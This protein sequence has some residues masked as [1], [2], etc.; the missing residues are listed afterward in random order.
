MEK[1]LILIYLLLLIN[2]ILPNDD[3]ISFKLETFQYK[4]EYTN[5]TIINKLYDTNLVTTMNIGSNYYPLKAFIDSQNNYFFISTKCNIQKSFFVDYKVNFNYDRHKSFSF[6]NTSSF[7]LSFSQESHA[8]TAREEFEIFKANKMETVK[9]TINF[10]LTE[11]TKEE[12]PNC[13]HIGLLENKNKESIFSEYNL[14]TQL[15]QKNHIKESGWFIIFNKL[16]TNDNLLVSADELLNLKGNLII[17]DYPHNYEPKKF[18]ESQFL[19]TYSKFENNIMKWELKFNKIYYLYNNKE[20]KILGENSVGFDP[21]NF[22]IIVPENYFDS[23][24]ENYFKKYK[25][26]NICNYDYLDEY[27]TIY[28]EK[29]DKFSLNEI[30][31]FP[32]LYLEHIELEYT[33]EISFQDLFIE[34]D[35]KFWLLLISDSEYRKDQWVLGNIFMRKYQLFFNLETKEIGF[36]NPK[37]EKKEKKLAKDSSKTFLYVLLILALCIIVAGIVYFIKMK[38]YP[39]VIKKKRANELDDDF[40]Y[41]SHKNIGLNK[42]NDNQLFNGNINQD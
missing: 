9:E 6:Q 3:I 40:E 2:L 22:F 38:F 14:I 30:K 27:I 23:I 16:I 15:K 4:G 32:T 42:D 35:G 28:C 1:Y 29:S 26:D 39:S 31:K 33:F 5:P 10:I 17:G 8:C 18:Y 12:I 25:D 7:D 36:Y 24:Y 37:L 34:K 41:V 21:S 13:L 19:K 11:D 20:I